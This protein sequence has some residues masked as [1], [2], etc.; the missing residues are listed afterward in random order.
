M[1]QIEVGS[2]A[3]IRSIA[4]RL[5]RNASVPSRE[6]GLQ[7]QPEYVVSLA[8]QRYRVRRPPILSS[9]RI[10]RPVLM[11]LRCSLFACPA[12]PGACRRLIGPSAR[13]VAS[14]PYPNGY[15]WI[16]RERTQQRPHPLPSSHRQVTAL[17]GRRRDHTSFAL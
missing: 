15:G 6:L 5:S 17:R 12:F 9:G 8:G 13:P 4:R 11:L 2:G 14:W 7:E 3:S 10:Q 1:L 16:R